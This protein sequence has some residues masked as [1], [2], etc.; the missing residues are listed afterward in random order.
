M[1]EKQNFEQNIRYAI[2]AAGLGAGLVL[3]IMAYAHATFPTKELVNERK[4]TQAKEFKELK[5]EVRTLNNW[6]RENHPSNK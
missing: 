2:W 3:T 6:L 4:D 5:D 1:T